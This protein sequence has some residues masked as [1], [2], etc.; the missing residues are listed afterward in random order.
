MKELIDSFL[1]YLSVERALAKNTI[2][3]YRADLNLYLDFIQQRQIPVLS[4]VT[5]ND[6]VEFMLSQKAEGI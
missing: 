6:I 1:D 5:K 2:V 4:K 3:A